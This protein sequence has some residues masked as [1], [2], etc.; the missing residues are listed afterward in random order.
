MVLYSTRYLPLSKMLLSYCG[1][2]SQHLRNHDNQT[3]Q[4]DKQI[5]RQ[6]LTDRWG[7]GGETN[8]QTDRQTNYKKQNK[9]KQNTQNK[10]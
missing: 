3:D 5:G 8:G 4:T 9:T 6:T 7:G 10:F 2:L 1:S